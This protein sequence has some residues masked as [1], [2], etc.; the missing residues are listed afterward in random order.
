MFSR[1]EF[2]RASLQGSTLVALAP[3]IP[4]FLAQTARAVSPQ[5]D[6][7]ILVVIQLDGGNDGINTV[8]PFADEGYAKY[9][10]FLRLPTQQL[11]KVDKQVGLHPAMAEVGK[12]LESN[13][14]AVV[15]GVGY[16]N[17]NRSHFESMAIWH[18]ARFN[19]DERND[20]GWI[21]RSLDEDKRPASGVP[22]CVF[23]GGG[24]L[25]VALRGRRSVASALTRPED[26]ILAPGAT[27]LRPK[28]ETEAK[29]DL[30]AFVLRSAL[31]AYATADRMAD[32]VRAKEDNGARYP[33]TELASQLRLMARLIKANVG[34]RVYYARQSGYDTHAAQ[35]GPHANL[36]GELS[37]AL[38]AFLDDLTA[39]KLADRIAV[40]AFSEFGRTVKE[41]GS[42]GTDHGTA[43][44]VF[45]AG[46]GVKPGLVGATPQL[47]DL[48][49][50]HGD[51][52]MGIDF[53]R[54]YATVLEDW[55]GLPVQTA[56]GGTFE[57]LPLFRL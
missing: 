23:V 56:L 42:A 26:F 39:A 12:L 53:R 5:R 34:T 19:P 9:R 1:R 49:P 41:N 18:T 17:P 38:R 24:Q 40:L 8:V 52:K 43:G 30:A 2:L 14:L 31:D 51:L 36:L 21:G 3:T 22:A 44:P 45:L 33:S 32:V 10:Q 7:R 20:L 57:R 48:D 11:I 55:V 35:L 37:G 29:M 54:V 28:S 46:T 27:P 6:G 4:G 15:Q 25:P 50:K 13:R 16:P 47:L